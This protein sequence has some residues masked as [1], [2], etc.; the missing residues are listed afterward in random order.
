LLSIG[1]LTSVIKGLVAKRFYAIVGLA[2]LAFGLFNINNA[3]N[4][5]GF[6][7]PAATN[8]GS[9]NSAEVIGGFQIVRM[10]QKS[11]GYSPNSFTVR[12]GIPV[13]WIITSEAPYSC[14][15]SIY[16]PVMKIQQNLR[17]GENIIQFTPTQT[18]RLPFSCS[19]G[20]YRGEFN[21]I[22]EGARAVPPPANF[23]KADAS[24]VQKVTSRDNRGLAPNEF[25]VKAGQPVEWTVI[26]DAPPA[27]CMVGFNSYELGIV[28]DETY[29]SPTVIRFTPTEPG[30]YDVTCPMGMW[31]ATIHVI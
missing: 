10:T 31:R 6:G 18:G 22:D 13:K 15:A 24:G 4:L 30:D 26:A 2:V 5:A 8:G 28:A 9:V 29:P 17:A 20:M 11:A 27:G 7:S 12:K 16:M 19:M 23:Q 21:V 1:G 3:L 25:T 14:A